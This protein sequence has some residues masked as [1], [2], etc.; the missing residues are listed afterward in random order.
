V[1]I[2]LTPD[3]LQR[4]RDQADAEAVDMTTFVRSRLLGTE[5]PP[6]ARRRSVDHQALARVLGQLGRLGGNVNQAVRIATQFHDLDLLHAYQAM[7]TEL[8]AI[9]KMVREALDR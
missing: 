9:R 8:A 5:I 1:T 2:R 4:L 3:E 7:Q 6:Q